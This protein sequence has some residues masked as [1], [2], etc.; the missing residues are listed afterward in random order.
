MLIV[1]DKA[2]DG[3]GAALFGLGGGCDCFCFTINPGCPPPVQIN[4]GCENCGGSTD[5]DPTSD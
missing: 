4:P 3:M 2:Q 5:D 1:R